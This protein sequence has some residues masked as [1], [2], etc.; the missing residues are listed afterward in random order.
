VPTAPPGAT[1]GEEPAAQEAPPQP[2]ADDEPRPS[3]RAGA[4]RFV[5]NL[6]GKDA[7]KLPDN[8]GRG[9]TA[10]ML[11]APRVPPGAYQVR[12]TVDGRT[13]TQ[14]FH[15][16][17]DPR[18]A[19]GD[20][21][22]REQYAWAGKAHDLLTRV[23]DA[24]VTL[25]DV[26]GQAEAWAGRVESTRVRDAARA[27]ARALTAIEGE[28]IQVQADDPRMF[29]SKLNS[30]LATVV[31]LIEYSDAA[32]TQ[33]LRELHDTLAGRI[34][35]ELAKLDRCLAEDVAAFNALCFDEGAPAISRKPASGR[36]S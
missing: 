6:R 15:V 18:I 8:K 29:P 2:V 35:G 20:E 28:L 31:T 34:Q 36:T 10:E 17:R 32:P 7:T 30:R 33:A 21:D 13:L 19:A 3:K 12:L 23:H 5:W 22:L 24:V 1:G 11:T 26:R 16:Q 4:N 27:L 14:P 25:R 9:G